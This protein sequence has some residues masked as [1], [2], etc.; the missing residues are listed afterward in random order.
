MELVHD[1]WLANIQDQCIIG[2]D[3]LTCWGPCVDTLKPAITLGT[4]TLAL[5]CEP[6]KEKGE[7]QRQTSQSPGSCRP[8]D[9]GHWCHTN[10]HQ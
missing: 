7:G 1:F 4:E 10:Y 9:I 2:L 6:E 5:H 3:L 8:T